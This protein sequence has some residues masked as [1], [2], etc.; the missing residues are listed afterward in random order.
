MS[1]LLP[2]PED[3]DIREWAS[4]LVSV[5][6]NSL[7]AGEIAQ[8]GAA[9]SSTQVFFDDDGRIILDNEGLHVFDGVGDLVIDANAVTID[10]AHL[11][12]AAVVTAKIANLAVDTEQLAAFAVEAAQ[13]ATD[14]VT[15][16]KVAASAISE[17]KISTNAVTT[18]KI[19]A[20]AVIAGKI[21]ANAIV[22]GDGVIA[23]AA[24]GTALIANLAVTTALIDNGAILTAKIG[25][26]QVTT[27]KIK[28]L[29]VDTAKINNLAVS[30]LKIGDNAVTIPVAAFT[31]ADLTLTTSFQDLQSV[32]VATGGAD[33][34]LSFS[35]T[36]FIANSAADSIIYE[37][38]RDGSS[39]SGNL[40]RF[41]KSGGTGTFSAVISGAV[42]F[43][44]TGATTTHTYKIVV[45][46]D[47]AVTGTITVGDRSLLALTLKK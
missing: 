7:D 43:T 31:G 27:A 23:N 21:A 1:V 25:N 32:T 45:K 5:L 37:I 2:S 42:N 30:T 34:Y 13:L 22:A 8:G 44:D 33:T 39:I 4:E 18:P 28:D 40:R 14:A 29:A 12:D 20:A 24:I 38:H 41:F 26:L 35:G 16:I 47:P 10:T 6:Q 3:K 17:T 15:G 11:V 46:A 19:N 36:A 9:G